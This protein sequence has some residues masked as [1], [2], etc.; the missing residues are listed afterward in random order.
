MTCFHIRRRCVSALEMGG[1]LACVWGLTV[2]VVA[3]SM[4]RPANER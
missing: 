1:T 2:F 3:R 4:R